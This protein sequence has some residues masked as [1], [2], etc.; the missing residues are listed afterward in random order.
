M[1]CPICKTDNKSGGR[2]CTACGSQLTLTCASCSFANAPGD[3]YCA[4]C[5]K[6]L[7]AL[8]TPAV[9]ANEQA[10]A[11]HPVHRRAGAGERKRVTVLFADLK[12]STA[13]I[14]GLDPEA[15]MHR[16]EP[17]LQIMV[18]LV[19][20]Y[21]GV[22]CRRL[23]DGILALFGAPVAHE[24][25]AVRACFAALG[26][27]R[28]LREAGMGDMVRV[29]LNSGDVLYRTIASDLGL[30][31][32]VVGP[33]VHLAARME[34]LA[35]AG[36]VYLTGETQA[37][38]QGLIEMRSI[39]LQ[40]IRGASAPI[41]VYEATGASMYVSRWQASSTRERAPFVGRTT[42]RATLET[43][44]EALDQKRG[45]VIG[46]SG[47]AGL[48]KS[49][50]VH[51]M[52]DAGSLA[53]AHKTIFAAATALGRT[54]PYH[55]L[56]SALR[57]LF[58]VAESDDIKRVRELVATLLAELD[59]SLV[60]NAAVFT[61]LISLSSATA[62]WLAMDPRQ[63]RVVAREA[64]V[65]LAR[66]VA[67]K[68]PL[69]L[70]FEDVHWIDRDSEE[71]VR[72]MAAL[73]AESPVLVVL[74]YRPEYDDAWL[75]GLGGTRLRIAPLAED[76]V[77]RALAEWFVE[78]PETERLIDRLTERAGGNPLFIEECVRSLA[79][80]GALTTLVVGAD[81]TT[82]RRR[83]A[84]WEAPESIRMPPS[85]HDVIA[86]RIDRRSP[87]CVALL[88]TLSMVGARVPLWL[89]TA[90]SG[91]PPAATE[92]ALLEAVAAE[93]L[94]QASLYPDV[95][96]VFAHALLR[97]VAHDSLTR[98]RRVEAH[99]RIVAA[100]E[101]HH[102]ERPRDQAE[103]LAH[104]AAEGELW[105]KAAI[106][107]GEASERALARGSYAEA[108][109]G[110]RM[111][112]KSYD[113]STAAPEA[114]GRA[115]DHLRTLRGLLYATGVDSRETLVI[116]ARAEELAHRL[117]DKVRLAWVWAD[118]SG[119]HW[120]AG[121][122][123]EAIATAR[124]CLD[125]AEQASDVRL[126]ALALHRMGLA[127]YSTG[128]YAGSA[129]ALR[130]TCALLS[131]DLR[132][133]RIGMAAI[134]TVI[135]GGWLVSALCE[136]GE[137]EQANQRLT[138]T[139]VSAAESRDIYSIASAQLTRCILAIARVDVTT[140]IPLLEG[141]LRAAKAGGALGVVQIMEV[142]L[143]RA[144]F[145][146][147]DLAGALKLLMGKN[148]TEGAERSYLHGIGAV[149]QAEALF[150]SG[151][152]EDAEALLR[153]AERDM[154]AGGEAGNLAHC[155]ALKGKLAMAQGDLAK[156]AS[157]FERS[158]AQAR[159]RSMRPVCEACEAE[160]AAIAALQSAASVQRNVEI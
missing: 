48:G 21:E 85:V 96:Y 134:T 37:L 53:G 102:A 43:A 7:V 97:E 132:F 77:R 125:I 63:K 9:P 62:D 80:E 113:R 4:D 5:G 86:S 17:A 130:Q 108:I 6:A 142:F 40:E 75:P 152:A 27:Q 150:A 131:G 101:G 34:Q 55:A 149:W 91:Q 72:A 8:V 74:T 23:G 114:I 54:I 94:V 121:E 24:D 84:C 145:L 19:N 58:R 76:D 18:R 69:V 123:R 56:A 13:A 103:W 20:R 3:R 90:V 146:A 107:Q 32:D 106:Y 52:I 124:R 11:R 135:A 122:Y 60:S 36:S 158:L 88:H 61:S 99:R 38:A 78:G 136:M 119:Q 16:L 68:T 133:E 110:M 41:E 143:G 115:I 93:I 92:A 155:W 42:E 139:M 153:Y 66:V 82:A 120:T 44:L 46:I 116:L 49:R 1:L 117:D 112:L 65:K 33:V 73:A 118:K 111:A 129:D 57:D 138:E 79:Q 64:C 83:Y 126:R 47:E 127:L 70:V 50:L 25:H 105:E 67:A 109:A 151:S 31:I 29:G 140:A 59:P 98:P 12:D 51:T 39:G 147:G 148:P 159:P 35:P 45:G 144:K 2:Y 71:V 154:L 100:I 157:E 128:D 156:A 95:E 160:L 10:A 141:L 87:E 81:G 15:A 30:E 22:V 89:A 28:E 14:E 137:L 104:H 26:M